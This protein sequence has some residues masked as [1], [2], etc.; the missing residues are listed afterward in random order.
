VTAQMPEIYFDQAQSVDGKCVQLEFQQTM[1]G[2]LPVLKITQCNDLDV[3]SHPLLTIL[4]SWL[5]ESQKATYT[6]FLQIVAELDVAYQGLILSVF[7]RDDLLQAFLDR[8]AS[9][10]HHHSVR[11]GL[12]AHSVDVAL[13]CAQSCR[14]HPTIDRDLAVTSGLLH[15]IGKAQEYRAAQGGRYSR[16]ESGELKMHKLQGAAIIEIAAA[17][18]GI[19]ARL[20]DKVIHCISACHA[21]DYVGLPRPKLPE[22]VMVQT[23]DA[24]SSGLDLYESKSRYAFNWTIL[25]RS[26][27][28]T[29]LKLECD[30]RDLRL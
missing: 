25:N 7:G 9:L 16:S 26:A 28:P 6:Q 15:D 2:E 19:D 29:A 10:A 30:S 13:D 3:G 23:A 24:R 21:P 17:R 14:F 18:T 12:L 22:A 1:I 20:V 4:P 8:P 27:G 5:Q 11:G